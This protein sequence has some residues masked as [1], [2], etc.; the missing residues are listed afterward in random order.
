VGLTPADFAGA[1]RAGTELAYVVDVPARSLTPCQD[2][3]T[4]V[5]LAP[6]LAADASAGQ[7]LALVPL[8]ETRDRAIMRRDR[9]SLSIDG[10]GTLRLIDAA[11]YATVRPP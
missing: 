5:A 1:L 11:P 9:V 3:D 2:M 4:L 8:I 10:D 7:A 6:W